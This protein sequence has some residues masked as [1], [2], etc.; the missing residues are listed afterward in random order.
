MFNEEN[1]V[2]NLV[3]DLLTNMKWDFIPRDEL[4][5]HETDVL[6]EEHLINSL[7]KLNPS[8]AQEPNRA[9]EVLYRL[10]TIILS[11]KVMG[12]VR[13]NEE[14]SRWIRNEKTMPFEEDGEHILR[15]RI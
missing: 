2:E 10:R 7:I 15:K 11:A 4:P 5:R 12:L 14:F 3:R 8:I 6:V 1:S 13:A 9:D